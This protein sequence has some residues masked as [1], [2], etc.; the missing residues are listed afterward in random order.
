MSRVP[1]IGR[2]RIN[3]YTYRGKRYTSFQKGWVK[4]GFKARKAFAKSAVRRWYA[5]NL[6]PN[7]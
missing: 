6:G 4:R 1:I 5:K 7:S 3:S 2:L